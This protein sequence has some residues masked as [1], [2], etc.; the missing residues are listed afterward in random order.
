M[1]CPPKVLRSGNGASRGAASPCMSKPLQGLQPGTEELLLCKQMCFSPFGKEKFSWD[2]KAD[3]SW[4]AVGHISLGWAHSG[5]VTH[6]KRLLN[7]QYAP[8][9]PTPQSEATATEA[10]RSYL[11]A[12]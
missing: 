9:C 10:E 1:T 5:S 3:A 4:N 11:E 7:V 6:R 12:Q 8:V 2:R